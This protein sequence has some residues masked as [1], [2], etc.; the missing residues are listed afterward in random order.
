MDQRSRFPFPAVTASTPAKNLVK[1]L[2]VIFG[3]YGYR[4]KIISDNGPLFKS[5]RIKDYFSKH[6]IIHHTIT[7]YWPLANGEV[8]RFIKPIMKVIQSTYIEQKD[9]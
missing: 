4:R 9:W 5:N 6:A 2:H 8:K 3:Q 1:V 7:P